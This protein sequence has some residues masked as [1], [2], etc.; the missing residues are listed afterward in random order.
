LLDSL[1]KDID[2]TTLFE[3]LGFVNQ[4]G[5]NLWKINKFEKAI[6]T[7][8]SKDDLSK[9]PEIEDF[10]WVYEDKKVKI[11]KKPSVEALLNEKLKKAYA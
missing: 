6:S 7:V 1:G 4:N 11:K 9:L 8:S 2:T 3:K 5:L 10:N